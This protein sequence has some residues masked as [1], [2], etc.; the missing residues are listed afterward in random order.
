MGG[1]GG[2]AA[3]PRLGKGVRHQNGIWPRWHRRAS[4]FNHSVRGA[5]RVFKFLSDLHALRAYYCSYD[6]DCQVLFTAQ[7]ISVIR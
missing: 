6:L 2:V 7:C 5:M 3:A 1:G 4:L